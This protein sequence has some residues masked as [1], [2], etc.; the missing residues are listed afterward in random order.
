MAKNPELEWIPFAKISKKDLKAIVP[1]FKKS[2][3]NYK[4]EQLD[5]MGQKNAS[6]LLYIEAISKHEAQ[7]IIDKIL[8][9]K[10]LKNNKKITDYSPDKRLIAVG[11]LM[12]LAVLI[13]QYLKFAT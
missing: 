13:R 12:V 1:M 5:N 4:V 11:I 7:K 6:K 8:L 9:E 10:K 2:K 3:I